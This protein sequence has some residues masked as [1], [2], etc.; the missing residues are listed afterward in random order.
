MEDEA[1][2]TINT[3]VGDNVVIADIISHNDYLDANNKV[4]YIKMIRE[5]IS[6]RGILDA[7]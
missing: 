1:Y 2:T 5:F 7:K 3:L 6:K 4:D